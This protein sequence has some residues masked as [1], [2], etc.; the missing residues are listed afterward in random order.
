[1]NKKNPLSSL[2]SG[3]VISNYSN[4]PL[5]ALLSPRAAILASGGNDYND[6]LKL[7]ETRVIT[8]ETEKIFFLVF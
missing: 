4:V 2:V 1:M 3:L 6:F 8:T 7:K 5:N